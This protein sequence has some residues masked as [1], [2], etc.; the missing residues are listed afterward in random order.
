MMDEKIT[1]A[2]NKILDQVHSKLDETPTIEVLAELGR[3]TDQVAWT[4]KNMKE[5]DKD[6]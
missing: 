6:D 1:S 3:I 2:L 5:E 4:K